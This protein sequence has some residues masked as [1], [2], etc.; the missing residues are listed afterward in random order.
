MKVATAAATTVV[1]ADDTSAGALTN[2]KDSL[3]V[4]MRQALSICRP[5]NSQEEMQRSPLKE[6]FFSVTK[7]K[8]LQEISRIRNFEGVAERDMNWYS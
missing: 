7:I 4:S 8:R 1:K 2:K 3:D 5:T 6:D